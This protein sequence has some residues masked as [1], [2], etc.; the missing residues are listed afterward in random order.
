MI[1]GKARPMKFIRSLFMFCRSVMQ[2]KT[3]FPETNLAVPRREF[4]TWWSIN[5]KRDQLSTHR[6]PKK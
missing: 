2:R 4:P 1:N 6:R 5:Q 3:G